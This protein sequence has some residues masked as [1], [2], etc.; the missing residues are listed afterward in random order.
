[1][2]QRRRFTESDIAAIVVWGHKWRALPTR[3]DMARRFGVTPATI[4]KIVK[5]G[6]YPPR[7]RKN[8]KSNVPRETN[9]MYSI[10]GD[11]CTQSPS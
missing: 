7:I 6:G 10:E 5:H 2:P 8:R 3:N 4:D 9:K 11:E 1:M